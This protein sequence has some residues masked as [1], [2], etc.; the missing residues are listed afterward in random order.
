MTQADIVIVTAEPSA[1]QLGANLAVSL[2]Q[3]D[4]NVTLAGIGGARMKDAGLSSQMSIEG[5]A[6][7]GF[8]EGLKSYGFVLKK[9]REATDIMSEINPKAVVLIDSWGFMVRIA[10]SLKRRGY[11]G[12]V[13]KY[14]APQVWATRPGRARVLARHVD[15]LLSTQ[16]MDA[17]YFEETGLPMTFVGNPVL[18]DTA[19]VSKDEAEGF[20][21]Q[22]QL[23]P[24]RPIYGI[25]PGSRPSEIERLDAG[26][27]R[28]VSEIAQRHPD[29]QPVCVVSEAVQDQVEALMTG[30]DVTL[31]PQS[32]RDV[33]LSVMS[34][35]LACSGTV[36][37]QLA[38]SAVP[39][40]VLYRL[41]PATFF[42]AKRIFQQRYVSLVNI[43]ADLNTPGGSDPLMPEFLQDE[44][45]TDAPIK[46]LSNFL[47]GGDSVNQL[48]VRLK[49]ET[50]RMGAGS[51]KASDKAAEIVLSLIA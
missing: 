23:D 6:I 17:P 19:D 49:K 3:L 36:T 7:L 51:E 22:Y 15:H 31:V 18:Q 37:T 9:V 24:D 38:M 48:R 32:S 44:V 25:F 10:K 28:I 34:A 26:I 21:T 33:A 39:T 42:L 20:L 50:R 12:K 40:V 45:L 2:R 4:P 13:I 27:V 8:F 47:A 30:L 14:I 29:A 43:S 16:S 1:D 5:L 41:S 35:A 11:R 46:A